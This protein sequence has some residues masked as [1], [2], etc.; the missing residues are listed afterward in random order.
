MGFC[1]E[2]GSG[3]GDG[4]GLVRVRGWMGRFDG[5]K[6]ARGFGHCYE[7]VG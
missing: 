5:R 7:S 3:D 6:E 2:R 4:R 1:G